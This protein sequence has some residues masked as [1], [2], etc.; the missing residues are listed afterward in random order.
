MYARVAQVRIQPERVAE[1]IAIY[2]KRV[3]PALTE[4]AGFRGVLLLTQ[5]ESGRGI[6]ITL[7]DSEE[8]RTSGE[9]SGFYQAQLAQFAG[10][11]SES[12]VRDAYE[13]AISI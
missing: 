4:Q 7:W 13:V 1:A 9:V 6:S 12:P 2:E 5:P 10:M 8:D 3:V 11:F